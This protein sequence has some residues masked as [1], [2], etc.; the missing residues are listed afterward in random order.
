MRAKRRSPSPGRSG[1]AGRLPPGQGACNDMGATL[2]RMAA[3]KP[4]CRAPDCTPAIGAPCPENRAISN[5]FG[6]PDTVRTCGLHLRRVALCPA[7]LRKRRGKIGPCE[8]VCPNGLECL[9]QRVPHALG[10]SQ[11][12][13]IHS[14]V[15]DFL[16]RIAAPSQEGARNWNAGIEDEPVVWAGLPSDDGALPCPHRADLP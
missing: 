7:E 11:M 5:V 12:L 8:K 1:L 4:T 16:C 14:P 2:S 13:C 9:L 3:L 10:S 15:P 6:A